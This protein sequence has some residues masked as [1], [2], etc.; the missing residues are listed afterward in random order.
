MATQRLC[1]IEGCGKTHHARSLC[2][3]HYELSRSKDDRP[4]KQETKY[5][6]LLRVA[7]P[8]SGDDCLIWPFARGPKGRGAVCHNSRILGAHREVCRLVHGEPTSVDLEAAH[9]CGNG[10]LGCVNPN[11]LRWATKMENVQDMIAHGRAGGAHKR[12]S[13][14]VAET[15]RMIRSDPRPTRTLARELGIGATTIWDIRHRKTWRH[16]A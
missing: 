6:W 7:V 4:P 15:V 12:R 14:V 9:S 3:T 13:P 5:E 8:Y 11:H 1:S 2:A 16:L 10:H